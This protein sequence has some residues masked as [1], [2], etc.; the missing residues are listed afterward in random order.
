MSTVVVCL[1]SDGVL[2][3]LAGAFYAVRWCCGGGGERP[4]W[5]CVAIANGLY[6]AAFWLAGWQPIAAVMGFGV[7]V[8][9]LLWIT[10][11]P[12][13][14]KRARRA[15]GGRARARLAA[16][17]AALRDRLVRRPALRPLPL[18]GGR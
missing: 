17:A 3:T 11:R 8:S 14:R 6:C 18:G 13:R 5:A 9:V 15:L 10:S 16:M 4:V 7:A 12:R 1:G 2:F